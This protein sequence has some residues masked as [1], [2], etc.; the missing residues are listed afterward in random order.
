MI[1]N[2]GTFQSRRVFKYYLIVSSSS[3][4]S[5]IRHLSLEGENEKI[6]VKKNVEW[7]RAF[8]CSH[9]YLLQPDRGK[10][11]EEG[12]RRRDSHPR[13]A[14]LLLVHSRTLSQSQSTT[15][16]C[17][18]ASVCSPFWSFLLSCFHLFFYSPASILGPRGSFVQ[19]V[20]IAPR[21]RVLA[22][23]ICMGP[24]WKVFRKGFVSCSH[25]G[26]WQKRSVQEHCPWALP[27][28]K[29]LEPPTPIL[30]AESA[31]PGLLNHSTS[32]SVAHTV[33]HL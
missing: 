3:P 8:I 10:K 31:Y 33:I 12:N 27:L 5:S 7:S 20:Q 19:S 21:S 28:S 2:V 14:D 18:S 17:E 22:P 4:G 26:C 6:R 13:D 29:V 32:A 9:R 16:V 25:P 23:C 1:S 24:G 30:N 15:D 11:S